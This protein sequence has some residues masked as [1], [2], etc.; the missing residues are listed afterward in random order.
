MCCS[1]CELGP[2]KKVV[3][4]AVPQAAAKPEPIV[5]AQ[6]VAQ[7]PEP[8]AIPPGSIPPRP[9]IEYQPP[10]KEVAP[11]PEPPQDPK[12]VRPPTRTTAARPVKHDPPVPE[13]TAPTTPPAEEAVVP[14]PKLS[15]A[16]EASFSRE[17]FNATLAEVQKILK[18]LSGRQQTAA[19]QATITRIHSFVRLAEQSVARNDLHGA[20]TLAHRALTLARDL[21]SPK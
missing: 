2:Q 14:P 15:A 17:E 3:V 11:E 10:V 16:D 19:S 18:E 6:T 5:V 12:V 9:P 1:S 7:L 13:P 4:P 20:D 8:Q 21:A